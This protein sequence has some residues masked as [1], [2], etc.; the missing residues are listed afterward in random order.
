M[1]RAIFKLSTNKTFIVSF[2]NVSMNSNKQICTSIRT[3]TSSAQ[4]NTKKLKS[5]E[6]IPGPPSTPFFGNVAGLKN[7]KYGHDPRYILESA[8]HLW[9]IH[10]DMWRLDIPGKHPIIW[11]IYEAFFELNPLI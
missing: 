9:P 11:Y 6:E 8:K 1:K 2:D 4:A 5:Y 7:P 10:G 3:L